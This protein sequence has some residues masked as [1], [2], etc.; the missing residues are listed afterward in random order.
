M[1]TIPGPPGRKREPSRSRPTAYDYLRPAGMK[2]G[3][4]GRAPG[5][6]ARSPRHPPPPT[7]P[8]I[9]T[10][11]PG[12]PGLKRE[13]CRPAATAKGNETLGPPGLKREGEEI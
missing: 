12:P 9:R 7:P 6:P 1:T 10:L 4:G 5:C 2:A 3:G 8:A 11:T 13:I